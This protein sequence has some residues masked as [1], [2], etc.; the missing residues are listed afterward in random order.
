MVLRKKN[1][2][3]KSKWRKHLH[4]LGSTCAENNQTQKH[5]A[6]FTHLMIYK[7]WKSFMLSS[8]LLGAFLYLVLFSHFAV[9]SECRMCCQ[10]GED[11]FFVVLFFRSFCMRFHKLQCVELPRLQQCELL[12]VPCLLKELSVSVLCNFQINGKA[13]VSI[14]MVSMRPLWLLFN[15][16]V[17]AVN[18]VWFTIQ[19]HPNHQ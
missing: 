18:G 15:L 12:M 9:Y 16:T 14:C 6:N 19:N 17:I 11:V 13:V 10:I 8:L 2:K 4:Q 1:K 7:P 3:N 5:A